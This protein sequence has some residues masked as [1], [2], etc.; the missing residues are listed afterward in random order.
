MKNAILRRFDG[1]WKKLA[2]VVLCLPI[3]GLVISLAAAAIF[4]QQVYLPSDTFSLAAC[5]Q[6]LATR[7]LRLPHVLNMN[8]EQRRKMY[9]LVNQRMNDR[10]SVDVRAIEKSRQFSD[11]LLGTHAGSSLLNLKFAMREARNFFVASLVLLFVAFS[12]K[13]L[14]RLWRWVAMQYRT[15]RQRGLELDQMTLTVKKAYLRDL[16]TDCVRIHVSQRNSIPR[17]EICRLWIGDKDKI[18]SVL[19]L[20]KGEENYIRLDAPLRHYFGVKE[21]EKA[22]VRLDSVFWW[23]KILWQ[24]R[25]SNSA[26]RT[27]A[28]ISLISLFLGL[29]SIVLGFLSLYIA[30]SS[31]C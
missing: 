8:D 22:C 23:H 29:T 11:C 17:G 12:V 13:P 28:Q 31:F 7:E 3:V 10:F 14:G 21:Y 25:A 30:I 6:D 1:R 9:S 19:G 2:F 4:W 27:S 15:S 18:V 5:H 24:W 20:G 26:L 16:D